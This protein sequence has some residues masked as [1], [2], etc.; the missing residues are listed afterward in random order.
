MPVLS[1]NG[2]VLSGDH[3]PLDIDAITPGLATIWY[4]PMWFLWSASYNGQNGSVMPSGG[5]G[6]FDVRIYKQGGGFDTGWRY[7]GI[8]GSLRWNDDN[9]ISFETWPLQVPGDVGIY[10][11]RDHL[12]PETEYVVCALETPAL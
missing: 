11:L 12:E 10:M 8:P 3:G 5:S 9:W 2:K 1:Y 7:G 6:E 4:N